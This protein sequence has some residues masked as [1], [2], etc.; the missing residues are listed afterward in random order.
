MKKQGRWQELLRLMGS[1]GKIAAAGKLAAGAASITVLSVG[2]QQIWKQFQQDSAFRPELFANSQELHG[3]QITFPENE[4][5]KGNDQT[6]DPGENERLQKDRRA[7]EDLGKQNRDQASFEMDAEDPNAFSG[8]MQNLLVAQDDQNS[9]VVPPSGLT[10]NAV[11]LTDGND[12]DSTDTIHTG[13]ANGISTGNTTGSGS[14]GSSTSENGNGSGSS[15][16]SDSSG[17]AGNGG[18]SGTAGGGSADTPQPDQPSNPDNPTPSP[19]PVR[20]VEPDQ[21]SDSDKVYDPDYPDDSIQPELPP[22]PSFDGAQLYP[23]FPEDGLSSNYTAE[24]IAY[25]FSI[26]DSLETLYEGAVLT[27]WKILCSAMFYM[28]VYDEDGM[29]LKQYRLT[30]Y[31]DCFRIGEYPKTAERGLT[32]TFYFRPNAECEW[33]EQEVT[34]YNIKYAK[35]VVLSGSDPDSPAAELMSGYLEEGEELS[36]SEATQSYFCAKP[37]WTQIDPDSGFTTRIMTEYFPGWSLE[38]QGELLRGDTFVPKKGGRYILYPMDPQPVPDG[39]EVQLWYE[40][41]TNWWTPDT[42]SQVLT[43]YPD[44]EKNAV[45]PVGVQN[46]QCAFPENMETLYIPGSVQKFFTIPR[47]LEAYEAEEDSQFFRAYDGVLYSTDGTSILG[48]PLKKTTLDVPADV[49]QVEIP[50]LNSLQEITLHSEM[51]PDMEISLLENVTIRIPAGSYLAYYSAWGNKMEGHIVF[52]TAEDE[53]T[54]YIMTE[55]GL[56][57]KDGHRLRKAVASCYGLYIVPDTIPKVE[58]IES[59]AFEDAEYIDSVMIP[60]TVKTLDSQSLSTS[61]IDRIYLY[62]SHTD[63]ENTIPSIEEDTFSIF[64]AVNKEEDGTITKELVAPHIWVPAGQREAYI[65]AWSDT[66]I[67]ALGKDLAEEFINERLHEEFS[68][69]TKNDFTWMSEGKDGKDGLALLHVPSGMDSFEEIQQALGTDEPMNWTRIGAHAFNY[70]YTMTMLE[71]PKSV[72]EIDA[73]AFARCTFLEVVFSHTEDMFYLGK[74]AFDN[75]P[76]LRFVVFNTKNILFERGSNMHGQ[77]TC[78]VP[79]ENTQYYYPD[80]YITPFLPVAVAYGNFYTAVSGEDG[81]FVYGYVNKTDPNSKS[82]TS[83]K[84][85][86]ITNIADSIA[87]TDLIEEDETI[88]NEESSSEESGSKENTSNA[89]AAIP[90]HSILIGA[91]TNVSG[92]LSLPNADQYPLTQVKSEALQKCGEDEIIIPQDLSS[93]IESIGLEA[94]SGSTLAGNLYFT[95]ALKEIGPGAFNKCSLLKSIHFGGASSPLLVRNTEGSPYY[96]GFE[97]N[98]PAVTITVSN[99]EAYL[100]DWKYYLSG[101]LP[102]EAESIR[103]KLREK[104]EFDKRMDWAFAGGDLDD[105]GNFDA[106]ID[107]VTDYYFRETLYEGEKR[108]CKLLGLDEPENPGLSGEPPIEDYLPEDAVPWEWAFPASPSNAIMIDEILNEDGTLDPE[109]P[110]DE[111]TDEDSG[112]EEDDGKQTP[113][114]PPAD[115]QTPGSLPPEN[116]T[117]DTESGGQDGNENTGSNGNGGDD[118]NNSSGKDGTEEDGKTDGTEDSGSSDKENQ[119]GFGSDGT[120]ENGAGSDGEKSGESTPDTGENGSDTGS[121]D[122]GESGSDTGNTD[123]GE[124]GSDNGNADSGKTDSGTG[125]S[126][127]DE[128]GSDDTDSENDTDA[129]TRETEI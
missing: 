21:P 38:P 36:L 52:E 42:F 1:K 60:A 61:G 119:N 96:F 78:Y 37:E 46:V 102:S 86:S 127:A 5:Y 53:D 94:F 109:D 105:T 27:D 118:E 17:G 45:I 126:G 81:Y 117:E 16:G 64:E 43:R 83:I 19:D 128:D 80:D 114:I 22:D 26:D 24:L 120:G 87:I 34:F 7:E 90:A 95:D 3:N 106:Y 47:V 51:P 6:S 31:N 101:Y 122:A 88:E 48:I 13:G 15:S 2:G 49:T 57:S 69:Q 111:E 116:K 93:T 20:P 71:L 58:R 91:T 121:T 11:L 115:D 30:E 79:Y 62:G 50:Y 75:T 23:H 54:D 35:Y 68:Y 70:N 67:S 41:S 110:L 129:G 89:A 44:D 29:P 8:D 28:Q 40:E 99:R 12:A 108:A 97:D 113:D 59:G 73:E 25:D 76:S 77:V 82:Q 85:Q 14:T 104:Y 124:N 98:E 9:A 4:E 66:L 10:G 32:I 112:Q 84:S 39:C 103:S 123:S 65:A 56:L 92:T 72:T 18:G 107:A 55:D 125:N 100:N 63:T 33:Q 74:A